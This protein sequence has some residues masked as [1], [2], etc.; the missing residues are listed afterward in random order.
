M[1]SWI[2]KN[3]ISVVRG[4]SLWTKLELLTADG[5]QYEPDPSDVIR[6]ALKTTTDD[7]EEPIISKIISPETME[8]KLNPEDTDMTPG[9]Y[10]YDIE[11]TL[12]NGYVCTCIGPNKFY[13]TDEVGNWRRWD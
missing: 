7:S 1:P 4:D 10:W 11:V 2:K 12:T 6:F 5:T 9:Q 3:V 8:L 13:I